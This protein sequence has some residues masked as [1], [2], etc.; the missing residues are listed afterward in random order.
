[1]RHLNLAGAAAVLILA[2]CAASPNGGGGSP[3][4]G[5]ANGS[6]PSERVFGT[7]EYYGEPAQMEVPDLV[8]QGQPFTVTV[9]TYGNG[10][11]EKGETKVEALR[12]VVRPYDYDTTPLGHDCDD[13]LRTYEHTATLSFEEAGTAEVVFYGLKE[14]A[15]G[16]TQTS[17]TRTVVV[18]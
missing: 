4:G 5:E 17:V 1:M 6:G 12:A 9:A 7:I 3:G 13:M 10:C 8:E 14:G 2:A 18:R 15:G 11:I 16:V